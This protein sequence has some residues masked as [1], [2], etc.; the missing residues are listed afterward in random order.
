[1][2]PIA[3]RMRPATLDDFVGQEQ[4]L[5][6]DKPLRRML[7]EGA[8]VSMMFWGPPGCGK[9]TLA[10]LIARLLK[11]EWFEL[12]AVASGVKDVRAVIEKAETMQRMG[13][14]VLLFVDEI[15]RFNK[16]QQDE[17]LHC[18]ERGIL[19]LIGATTENP[20][21]EV[22]TPLLS[23]CRVFVLEPLT[24]E[25]LHTVLHLALTNDVELKT[26]N[27]TIPE[28]DFLLRLSGG[29]ARVLLGALELAVMTAKPVDGKLVLT[30][31]ILAEV[32]QRKLSRYDKGGE[33][34]YNIISAFIKSMRGN[35][36]D[37]AVYW[38]A[39]MLDGGKDILF[40]ARRM[41]I[42]ASEDIGNANPVALL[43]ATSAFQACHQIGMPE[44]RI[45]LAQAATYLASSP[46]SNASYAAIGAA[47]KDVQQFPNEPVPM[48]IR[49][50]PTNLMKDIG[51]GAGYKYGH[52][53]EGAFTEQ[54]YLPDAL[55]DRI[56]Y[57]PTEEGNEKTIKERLEMWWKK[58]REKTERNGGK[59]G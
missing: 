41:V 18:V 35:D 17:L 20:S 7:E 12:S 38:L 13:L 8:I 21:F 44:A 6:A 14:K 10:K 37:A 2:I 36:P 40:I 45:I 33:E 9:T 28:E 47:M 53:Y 50:A 5:G 11:V 46:K 59:T 23:R 3:E 39:R 15:H 51:Y 52:S 24:Q 22:I 19:T 42:L 54:E 57:K 25:N 26:K 49:N 55:K 4:L 56:Y 48:H 30:N 43:L 27:I 29:D 1:M 34:H 16:S 32:F 58:R 31:E